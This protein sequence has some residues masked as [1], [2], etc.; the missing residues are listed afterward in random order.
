VE[1]LVELCNERILL[2]HRSAQLL[3]FGDDRVSVVP[4]L[5]HFVEQAVNL[6]LVPL[7]GRDD[8]LAPC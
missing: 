6:E 7:H 8:L 1:L 4:V 2:L 3:E 5:L